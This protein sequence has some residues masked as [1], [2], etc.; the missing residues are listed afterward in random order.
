MTYIVTYCDFLKHKGFKKQTMF[1]SFFLYVYKIMC[2]D[3]ELNSLTALGMK[4]VCIFFSDGS[5]VNRLT[6]VGVV[7]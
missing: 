6:G 3:D 2:V 5:R 1:E 4:M 7:F